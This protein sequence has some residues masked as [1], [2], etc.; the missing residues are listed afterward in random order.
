MKKLALASLL[1]SAFALNPAFAA[2]AKK[3]FADIEANL[4]K[5][6]PDIP[7]IKAIKASPI[8]GLYEVIL[9]EQG[10]FYA[11]KE[12]KHLLFGNLIKLDNGRKINLTEERMQELTPK[13]DFK[14]LKLSDAVTRKI[15]NGKNVIVTFE[16]PNCGFCKKLHPEL[17]KLNNVTIHTFIVPILGENSREASKGIICSKD[18]EK[19]WDEYMVDGTK[20]NV[21]QSVLD[22]CDISSLDRN[23]ALSRKLRVT[24]TPAIFFENGKSLK[25]YAPYDRIIEVMNT[26]ASKK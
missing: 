19:A 10:I 21:S 22:K 8:P 7:A 13:L 25:G 9:E 14:D 15:G 4:K 1:L 3:E 26:P 23:I 6:S 2:T 24:G 11:D 17:S 12:A 18:S 16:D 20:P 5:N